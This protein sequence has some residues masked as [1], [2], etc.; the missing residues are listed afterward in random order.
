MNLYE[1]LEYRAYLKSYYE[2][3]KIQSRY[4][5]YKIFAS[6]LGMDQSHLAKILIG[7]MHLPIE[8]I[9][10]V[11]QY[12][13][14]QPNESQYFE[15]LVHFGRADTRAAADVWFEKLQSLRPP[16]FRALA[17]DQFEYFVHWYTPVIR[18]WLGCTRQWDASHAVRSLQPPIGLEEARKA[19]QTLQELG[20]IDCT[21]ESIS[22]TEPHIG[23][24]HVPRNRVMR[25]YHRQVLGIALRALDELPVEER[26]IS[27]LV[28]ALDDE[29]FADVRDMI[30][31]FRMAL[32]K[33]AGQ[34]HN[35]NKV[36]HVNFQ[37]IPVAA[38]NSNNN[39]PENKQ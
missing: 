7:Q 24:G 33:R 35:A 2:T 4:Y 9:A 8:K 27:S 5:S 25:D 31:D 21:G 34:V 16:Q 19:F 13:E 38:D 11:C 36:Y 37:L 12:L 23:S 10:G 15:C 18:S 28:L 6:A 30:R 17:P 32:Q 39:Q 29:A 14:L 3:R 22:L 1:T 26:D 20:M